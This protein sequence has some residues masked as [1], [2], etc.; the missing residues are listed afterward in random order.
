MLTKIPCYC[1]C[2]QAGHKTLLDCFLKSGR[3]GVIR[4]ASYCLTCYTEAILAFLWW[5]LGTTESEI[6]EGWQNGLGWRWK[7]VDDGFGEPGRRCPGSVTVDEDTNGQGCTNKPAVFFFAI[8][9]TLISPFTIS[10]S[11]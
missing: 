7:H 4:H 6:R 9:P 3:Q 5:D 11:K 10:A 2:D 8:S 1:V